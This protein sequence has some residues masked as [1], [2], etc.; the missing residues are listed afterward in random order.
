MNERSAG[1]GDV[2]EL[3]LHPAQQVRLVHL[4]VGIGLCGMAHQSVVSRQQHFDQFR[5]GVERGLR[6]SV[7]ESPPFDRPVR[8]RRRGGVS[9]DLDPIAGAQACSALDRVSSAT[10]RHFSNGHFGIAPRVGGR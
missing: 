5:R 9:P 3:E 10:P 1:E 6:Q 7:R 8:R 4:Q 2:I